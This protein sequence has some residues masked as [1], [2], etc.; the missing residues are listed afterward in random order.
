MK[1]GGKCTFDKSNQINKD[2]WNRD[3]RKWR[4]GMNK[5]IA[6]LD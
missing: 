4:F 2:S 5:D 6:Q 1:S 3:A